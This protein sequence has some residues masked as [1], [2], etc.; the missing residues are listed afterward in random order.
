MTK[1]KSTNF[2]EK[3][4]S[5]LWCSLAA[6]CF[7][8]DYIFMDPRVQDILISGILW[9]SFAIFEFIRCYKKSK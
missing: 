4:N 8:V 3:Y 1:T 5:A 2:F 9:T 6:L 7:Y